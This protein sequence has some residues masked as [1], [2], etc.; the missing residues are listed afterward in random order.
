MKGPKSNWVE[1]DDGWHKSDTS[2][3][4]GNADYFSRPAPPLCATQP[5]VIPS[6]MARSIGSASAMIST[7]G[8]TMA[9][10]SIPQLIPL[11]EDKKRYQVV[12]QTSIPS[13]MFVCEDDIVFTLP[14]LFVFVQEVEMPLGGAG[15]P[16]LA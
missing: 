15:P 12:K 3:S 2:S 7:S 6:K 4:R 8:T 14:I 11:E 1:K 5:P 16:K 10:P 13:Q 9:E